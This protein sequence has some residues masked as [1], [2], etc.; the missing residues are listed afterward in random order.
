MKIAG[1]EV[2]PEDYLGEEL[3]TDKKTDVIRLSDDQQNALKILLD[4]LH[5]STSK[6]ALLQ[7][8]PG[9]G[10]TF[11]LKE[12]LKQYKY[13]AVC[14]AP[15]NKATKVLKDMLTSDRYKP[16]CCTIFKLLNLTMSSDGEVKEL[17][18]PDKEVDISRFSLVIIDEAFMINSQLKAVLDDV[19]LYQPIKILFIGDEYQLPPVG[20]PKS[21]IVDYFT[22]G[23][24]PSIML[25][26]VMRH[27][28]N[29]L[30]CVNQ[31]RAAINFPM[32]YKLPFLNTFRCKDLEK[33]GI[34]VI[35]M[36][37]FINMIQKEAQETDNFTKPGESKV[38]AWRNAT[39]SSY[40][41]EIRKILFPNSYF[42][43]PWEIGDRI[44]VTEPAKSL[45]DKVFATVD[46]EGTVQGVVYGRHTYLDG[47][48]VYSVNCMMDDN[49]IKTFTVVAE[50]SLEIFNN[51]LAQK[52][53]AAREN[54]RLWKEY[55]ALHEAVHYIRH[56]YAITSH[57]A[58]GSTYKKVFC[59]L[60]DI[61]ANK[62]KREALQCLNVA[63]SRA[64]DYLIIGK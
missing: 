16:D 60:H 61:L 64:K 41:L 44:T 9:T 33:E 2:K 13:R 56:S 18:I 37:D 21:A 48:N 42:K 43:N 3:P 27:S 25:H 35:G 39:V 32:A 34:S 15:T 4:F 24:N 31:V 6:V 38:I 50:D 36:R 23:L 22:D 10:K 51:I 62:S 29:I 59:N 12:V 53:L 14:T 20:E 45:E 17:A 28:G 52:R 26:E 5:N 57:R 47:I 8:K 63:M 1:Q 19:L 46:E 11:V 55:W 58:Q 54:K 40:N 30:E 49:F 7:G